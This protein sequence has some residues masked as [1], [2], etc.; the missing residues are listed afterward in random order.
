MPL[1]LLGAAIALLLVLIVTLKL[2][3][4]LALVLTS[5]LVGVANGM[6]PSAALN[7]ILK[8][9]GDTMG[10]LVLIVVSGAALGKLIEESGAAHTVSNSLTK[11]FGLKRIQISMVLTGFLVGLPMFYNASFL[12]LTPLVYAMSAT[13]GL[14]LLWL[15]IPMS[16]ALSVTHGFLPPHPAPTAVAAMF[17]ADANQ[18][19]L[20]GILL[21]IPAILL[22]GPVLARFFRHTT[23]QP[24]PGLYQHREFRA[25]ELP[26]L[27][28]SLFTI[29]IPV[30]LML[31]GAVVTMTTQ[32]GG[33]LLATAKFLSDPNVALLLAMLVGIY[34]LGI[35]RGRD[36]E[37]LMKSVATATASVSML[38]LI[39]ASG[40]AFKQILLDCG[41]AE[42][43]KAI[44]A[45]AGL[46]PI[47]LAWGTAALLRFAIGSATVAALTAAGIM[48]PIVP[49]C[50][51]RP[52][53][54]VIAVSTGSLMFSHFNDTGFWMFKEYYGAT[55]KQ[56][57]QVWT[58]MEC[59]VGTAGLAGA[60]M[61]NSLVGPRP[62]GTT[63]HSAPA[64][65][66]YHAGVAERRRPLTI[67]S[68]TQISRPMR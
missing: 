13:T 51:V 68:T 64:A 19:L 31:A 37:G 29:L 39:I 65:P 45:Q 11:L 25:E 14:P 24:P 4:F 58:V 40:G 53:I 35:R 46:S 15:G 44:T 54:M 47:L 3:P 22:G 42:V 61:L 48:L 16:A 50:G 17:H 8:G 56:T 7:S 5:F 18:T 55:V 1:I 43:V 33:P 60:L 21:S 32:D 36:M 57:F 28:V 59:I 9:I 26:G 41:T 12:V 27:G 6:A 30:L 49:V 20:F 38:L 10:A 67:P 62:A 66:S 63:S 34:T 23:N 52:E 2:N